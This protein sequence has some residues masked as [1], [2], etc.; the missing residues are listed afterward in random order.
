MRNRIDQQ[1]QPKDIRQKNEFLPHIRAHLADLREEHETGL[2][3]LEAEASFAGEVVDVLDEA[4]HY[5]FGAGVGALAV[6]ELGVFRY[7]LDCEVFEMRE[8]GEIVGFWGWDCV[9][10]Y[11]FG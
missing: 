2:P 8:G 10:G 11:L 5:V 6:Y 9:V 1:A 4:F 3:F 7:V